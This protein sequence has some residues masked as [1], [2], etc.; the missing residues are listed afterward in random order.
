MSDCRCVQPQGQGRLRLGAGLRYYLIGLLSNT[1]IMCSRSF[2]MDLRRSHRCPGPRLQA[3]RR[4]RP[5]RRSS[6]YG[7]SARPHELGLQDSVGSCHVRGHG[8]SA[9]WV[10]AGRQGEADLYQK[11][12]ASAEVAGRAML[13]VIDAGQRAGVTESSCGNCGHVRSCHE[14]DECWADIT[15]V[16]EGSYEQCPC[17]WWDDPDASEPTEAGGVKRSTHHWLG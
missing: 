2:T 13:S 8:L 15:P 10:S 5:G 7:C 12:M 3:M 4:V 1:A 17:G 9:S 11:G 6:D 14:D 16:G